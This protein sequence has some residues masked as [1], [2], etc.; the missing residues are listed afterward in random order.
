MLQLSYVR[1]VFVSF[2]DGGRRIDVPTNGRVIVA[3]TPRN[4]R[5]QEALQAL[6]VPESRHILATLQE[7]QDRDFHLYTMEDVCRVL[8]EAALAR[9]RTEAR[10]TSDRKTDADRRRTV[11]ARLPVALADHYKALAK[12]SGRSLYEFT[13]D[14][15]AREASR[16]EEELEAQEGDPITIQGW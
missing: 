2:T 5:L 3:M 1:S 10:R 16:T 12:R 14:A 8:G 6:P 11:G 4:K 9:A 7:L 15:L 13:C